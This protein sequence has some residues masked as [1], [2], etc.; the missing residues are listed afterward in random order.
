MTT[1]PRQPIRTITMG[2]TLQAVGGGLGW[3]LLPPLMPMG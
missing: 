2:A 3:S 1:S